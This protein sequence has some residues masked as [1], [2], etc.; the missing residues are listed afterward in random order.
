VVVV[1]VVVVIVLVA[2]VVAFALVGR[3]AGSPADDVAVPAA[4]PPEPERA[5]RPDPEPMRGL[6]D[7]LNRAT[8]RSGATMA[9]R[10]DAEA[11]KVEG[12]RERDDTGPLLRRALD[13]V[14]PAAATSADETGERVDD[15]TGVVDDD[16]SDAP[17]GP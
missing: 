9:Q 16:A 1:V 6:E 14:N 5:S 8:D 12:F 15:E 10:L 11:D 13:R 7:A 3:R 2:A 17:S 4:P